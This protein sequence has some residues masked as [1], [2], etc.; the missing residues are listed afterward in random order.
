MPK[1]VVDF[2]DATDQKLRVWMAE[3]G[4]TSKAEAIVNLL[5]VA[6]GVVHED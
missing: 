5:K 3:N 4:Y 6:L 1:S 2:D